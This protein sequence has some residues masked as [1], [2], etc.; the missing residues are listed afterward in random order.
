M[1]AERKQCPG[2]DV[3]MPQFSSSARRPVSLKT[4]RDALSVGV[5]DSFSTVYSTDVI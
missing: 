2:K 5:L 1:K 3:L 4:N